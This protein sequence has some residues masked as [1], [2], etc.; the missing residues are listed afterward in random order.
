MK[1]VICIAPLIKKITVHIERKRAMKAIKATMN[2]AFRLKWYT[3]SCTDNSQNKVLNFNS[4]PII[5][6]KDVFQNNN[7][8]KLIEKNK[9]KIAS[10]MMSSGTSGTLA[11]GVMKRA[12]LKKAIK[13]TDRFLN[14]VFG[15]KKGES[16]VINALAMGVKVFTGHAV[17]DTGPRC[18]LVAAILENVAP[19]YNKVLV[20][21]D[22]LIIKQTVELLQTKKFD[23]TEQKMFFI[24]GGDWLPE[25]LRNYVYNICKMDKYKPHEGFWMSVYGITELGYPV[26]FETPELIIR[27]NKLRTASSSFDPA[28]ISPPLQFIYNT[29]DFHVECIEN[30]G[31]KHRIVVTTLNKERLIP[32]IRY[33][34]G[35]LGRFAKYKDKNGLPVILFWGRDNNCLNYGDKQIYVTDI[36]EL[37]FKNKT[38]AAAITG[39]FIMFNKDKKV[40]LT[41]Q[42]K[43]GASIAKIVAEELYLLI[44]SIYPD[45]FEISF[46]KYHEVKHQMELD[47]ERKFNPLIR[48]YNE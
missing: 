37:L 16:L 3:T 29:N 40:T 19:Y 41:I 4:A 27:R 42:L 10:I 2:K 31:G 22:P 18:D 48:N 24:S 46:A 17:S 13:K 43:P 38:L 25:S 11:F 20:V 9:G 36:K 34:T 30:P 35:D 47:F 32:L 44:N 21:A 26:F 33:D 23:W 14:A 12:E 28:R 7:F 15:L 39:H 45:V 8:N 1:R 5:S 6:K